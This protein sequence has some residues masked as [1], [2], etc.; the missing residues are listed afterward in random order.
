[1]RFHSTVQPMAASYSGTIWKW[2]AHFC[3]IAPRAIGRFSLARRARFLVDLSCD[4]VQCLPCDV[5]Y[6]PV[7]IQNR[8]IQRTLLL[9]IIREKE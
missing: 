6:L 2:Y 5:H 8:L 9:Y 1:M 3:L 4:S 7:N